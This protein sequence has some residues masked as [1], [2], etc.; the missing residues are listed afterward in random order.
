MIISPVRNL[1][2]VLR[3]QQARRIAFFGHDL[4][5]QLRSLTAA[6]IDFQVANPTAP[7]ERIL[8][9]FRGAPPGALQIEPVTSSLCSWFPYRARAAST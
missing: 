7:L 9:S 1:A 4:D 3:Q 2:E 5:V 6:G 8:Q